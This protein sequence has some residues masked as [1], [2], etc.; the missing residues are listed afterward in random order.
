MEIKIRGT[1]GHGMGYG[2]ALGFPTV[3]LDRRGWSHRKEKPMLGIHA[4]VVYLMKSGRKYKAAIVIGRRD[5]KGL[6]KIEAHHLCF[7]G[8]VYGEKCELSFKK[9]LRKFISFSDTEA[10]KRQIALDVAK[11]D[12]LINI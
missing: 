3:N 8:N 7:S 6:P 10:L 11:V 12:D 5:R 4:G 1:I 9:F 2:R